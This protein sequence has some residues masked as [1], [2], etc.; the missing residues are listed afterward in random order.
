RLTRGVFL[1]DDPNEPLAALEDALIQC[2]SVEELESKIR[3]AGHAGD[4]DGAMKAGVI[5]LL[6][7]SRLLLAARARNHCIQV[8]DFKPVFHYKEKAA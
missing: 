8:D 7:A 6:D 4:L 1:P 3:H 5:T 2:L